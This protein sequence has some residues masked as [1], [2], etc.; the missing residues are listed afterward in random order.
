MR[1][2]VLL[3][4]LVVMQ[5]AR[6]ALAADSDRDMAA[7]V[8]DLTNVERQKAALQPLRRSPPLDTSATQYA[9]VL[10]TTDACFGHTC[11]P[12][13]N[14]ADR[15]QQAGYTSWL[16]LGEN[17]AAGYPTPA[18]VVAGWMASPPHHE[19]IVDPHFTEIGV[20][21]V[22][23][24]S[25]HHLYWVQEFGERVSAASMPSPSPMPA[26]T[27]AELGTDDE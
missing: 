17:V 24:S 2:L 25:G 3:T 1:T 10:S 26:P 6:L 14:L 13:P 20:G 9:T 7:Q 19:N 8:I 22:T 16:L 21:V 18:S 15:D 27:D 5:P 4:L 12:V 11:G 23:T